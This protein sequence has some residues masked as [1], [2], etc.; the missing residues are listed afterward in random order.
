MQYSS[1][2]LII[3]KLIT[4][5]RAL[6]NHFNYKVTD[7]EP[8]RLYIVYYIVTNV[9]NQLMSTNKPGYKKKR[10]PPEGV[11]QQMWSA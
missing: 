3:L 2:F 8:L 11:G 10:S 1:A 5:S 9:L 7:G 6:P 4:V